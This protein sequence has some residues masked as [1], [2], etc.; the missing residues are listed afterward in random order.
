MA[1]LIWTLS[2][3]NDLDSIAEYISIDS[4]IAVKKFV[5][6]IIAKADTI[7]FHP[8]KG[9]PIP[10]RIPGGYRQILHKSYRIIYKVE[11]EKIYVSSIYHQKRLLFKINDY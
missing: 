4:E 2:A 9:R 8:L 1:Q 6:E 10:E 5:G 7:I 3:I 11:N